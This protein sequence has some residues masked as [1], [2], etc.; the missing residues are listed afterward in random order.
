MSEQKSEK[1]LSVS[2]ASPPHISS[3]IAGAVLLL[4]SAPTR[5]RQAPYSAWMPAYRAVQT[6]SRFRALG[7]TTRWTL[8]GCSPWLLRT[9]LP[10]VAAASIVRAGLGSFG[11]LCC[12]WRALTQAPNQDRATRLITRES[13]RVNNKG[14]QQS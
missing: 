4:C 8:L 10:V 9:R 12:F 14:A 11:A 6:P 13:N 1:D 5:R 2:C 7:W 3:S